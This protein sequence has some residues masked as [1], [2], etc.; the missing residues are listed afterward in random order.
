MATKQPHE[1]FVVLVISFKVQ[2][3]V[4][5]NDETIGEELAKQIEP[6]KIWLDQNTFATIDGIE[7]EHNAVI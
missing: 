7:H 4:K 1:Q 2:S 3:T 5:I 6:Q